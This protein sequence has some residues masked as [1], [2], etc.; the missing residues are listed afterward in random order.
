MGRGWAL[1][2][3]RLAATTALAVLVSGCGG[4]TTPTR[5]RVQAAL[6][7]SGIPAAEARCATRELFSVL[8]GHQLRNLAERGSGALDDK[9]ST[10]LST[11]LGTCAPSAGSGGT[12]PDTTAPSPST[13]PQTAPSTSRP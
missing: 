1:R 13:K 12:E 11:A 8:S 10:A 2:A 9:T 5:P 6:I 7:T 4:G 3:G